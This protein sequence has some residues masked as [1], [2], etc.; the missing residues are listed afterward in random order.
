MGL[1]CGCPLEDEIVDI[2]LP[3]CF[4]DFGEIQK[5][6]LQRQYASAG[7]KNAFTIASANPALKASWTAKLTASDDTKIQITPFIHASNLTPGEKLEYGGNG[8]TVGGIP[9]VTGRA[10][11][12]FT[13]MFLRSP[14]ETIKAL[15][16]YGCEDLAVY[17]V[18]EHGQIGG[19]TDDH[20]TPTKFFPIP[21][22][23]LFIGD[24]KTGLKAEPDSNAIQFY[25]RPNWSDMFHVIAPTDFDALTELVN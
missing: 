12:A 5:M 15:K 23:S 9:I 3:L 8:Q 7:T 14:Q 1:L 22:Q 11:S 16:A 20:G 4:E 24:K 10:H 21:I 6:L 17:F 19:L 18:N 13:G 25:L 2:P